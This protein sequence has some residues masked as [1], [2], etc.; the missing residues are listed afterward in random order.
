MSVYPSVLH[1]LCNKY[2]LGIS[3]IS[4]TGTCGLHTDAS[5]N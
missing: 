5:A 3:L 1:N 4:V 2:L